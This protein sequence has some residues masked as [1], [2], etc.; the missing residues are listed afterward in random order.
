[1]RPELD[2]ED[3]G[4]KKTS[5]IQGFEIL[6]DPIS[7]ERFLLRKYLEFMSHPLL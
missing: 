3:L 2:E 7:Q 1:M 4:F 5:A 6:Q